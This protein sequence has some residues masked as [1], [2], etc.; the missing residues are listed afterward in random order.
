MVSISLVLGCCSLMHLLTFLF[1]QWFSF[2]TSMAILYYMEHGKESA[3]KDSNLFQNSLL[4]EVE[5]AK[6]QLEETQHD[7]VLKCSPSH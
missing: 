6:K 4:R 7:K 5:N 2:Q 3:L 1:L